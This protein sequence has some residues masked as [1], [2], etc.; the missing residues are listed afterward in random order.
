M[1]NISSKN[2]PVNKTV[3]VLTTPR[4]SVCR[5]MFESGKCI[6]LKLNKQIVLV[7]RNSA[8]TIVNKVIFKSTNP[9]KMFHTLLIQ[10]SIDE[11]DVQWEKDVSVET[12]KNRELFNILDNFNIQ[13]I[14]AFF[15]RDEK[16]GDITMM[17][18]ETF[19][20]LF[21]DK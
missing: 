8:D 17:E 10:Q 14:P 7:D 1:L 19:N 12:N 5:E 2:N 4:C 13:G 20:E 9:L 6:N 3:I 21:L 18:E 15:I 16:S 11:K